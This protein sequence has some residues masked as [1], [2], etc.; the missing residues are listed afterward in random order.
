MD[1]TFMA[2]SH[3]ENSHSS[4]ILT[5]NFCFPYWIAKEKKIHIMETQHN[6]EPWVESR[7]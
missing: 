1:I 6:E 7:C 4:S 3:Y 5:L 2:A